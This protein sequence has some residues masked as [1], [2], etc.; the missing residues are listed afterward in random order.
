MVRNYAE[1]GCECGV[2]GVYFGVPL[3]PFYQRREQVRIVIT[4]D[5]FEDSCHAF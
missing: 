5:A 2:I 4:D 1:G 3:R